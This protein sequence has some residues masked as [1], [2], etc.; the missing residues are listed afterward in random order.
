MDDRDGRPPHERIVALERAV[1]DGHADEGLPDAA[2]M[3]TRVDDV[4]TTLDDVDD[5]VDELEAAVQALRGF[6]GG[7]Q[8]VDE[9]VE[10]RADT[11]VARVERLETELADLRERIDDGEGGRT[12]DTDANGG[13]R[14]TD[15][16]E[17][18][19]DGSSDVAGRPGNDRSTEKR[20]TTER[21]PEGRPATADTD[22]GFDRGCDH[23]R[24]RDRDSLAGEVA[25]R[26]DAAVTDA[27][28]ADAAA[29]A[30]RP[31][32]TDDDRSLAERIRRLL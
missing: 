11:A 25:A 5:R 26:S 29:A 31:D 23:D 8:A 1:T 32:E 28:L 14:A 2:R 27:A 6:A 12:P 17:E 24:D 15:R 18:A 22:T 3:E 21:S 13:A 30:D 10:R 4:E 9:E 19:V 7:I 16:R 20:Y